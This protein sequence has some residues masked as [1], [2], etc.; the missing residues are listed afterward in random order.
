MVNG[1]AKVINDDKILELKQNQSTYIPVGA[2]HRLE[3]LGSDF[4][5]LIEVQCGDYLGEDDIVR[6]EDKYG[7][8]A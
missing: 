6:Y 3:N 5:V 2:K 4:L 8:C 1:V 7:R